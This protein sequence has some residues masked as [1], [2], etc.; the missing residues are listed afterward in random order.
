MSIWGKLFGAEKVV[1]AGIKAGDA[2]FF[3]AEEKSEWHLRL[4]KAYEPFKIAQRWLAILL[5]TPFVTLHTLA[6]AQLIIMGW[7][8]SELQ[9]S[10]HEASLALIEHNN[11]TLGL[12]VAI[13]LGFYFGGG[14]LES[15][16]KKK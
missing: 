2:L 7:L 16:N 10:V 13:V 12:P 3:T 6:G 15:Y 4:L 1:D 8:P 5:T 14:M 11:D 9:K